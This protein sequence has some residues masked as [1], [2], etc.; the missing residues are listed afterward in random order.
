MDF[1]EGLPNSGKF[2]ALWVVVD[3]FTK[4]GHFVPIS[5]PYTAKVVAQLFRKHMFKLHRMPQSIVSDRDPSFTSSARWEE[6][7]V[8][9]RNREQLWN[10][11]EQK[12]V[13]AQERMRK[14]ANSKRKE[15]SYQIG[16]WVFLKL[17][18]YRQSSIS[19]CQSLKLSP[20]YYGPYQVEQRIGE[21]A[22]HLK[23]PA[24]TQIHSVFH[25]SQ[26]KPKLSQGV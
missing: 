10:L 4:Y 23:L 13:K 7:K 11:L 26:L 19:W 22:Y 1:V 17:Q 20:R 8:T 21:V 24:A 14:Y 18:P 15:Q 9:L 6:V 25:V 3:R 5:H 12:M 16:D 2:N